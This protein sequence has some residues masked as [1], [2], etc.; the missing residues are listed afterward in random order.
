MV[1]IKRLRSNKIE[2]WMSAISLKYLSYDILT[3][4]NHCMIYIIGTTR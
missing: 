4:T 3:Q 1:I 2:Q